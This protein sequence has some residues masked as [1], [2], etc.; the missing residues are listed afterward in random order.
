[1][2]VSTDDIITAP[3]QEF[4]RI[5]GIGRSKTYEL[6]DEGKLQSIKIGK[7]RLIV[8]RSWKQL[9]E[10]KLAAAAQA[11]LMQYEPAAKWPPRACQHPEAGILQKTA[12]RYRQRRSDP[13]KH[14]NEQCPS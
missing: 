10:E 6:L 2:D 12:S 5:S 4:C 3:I 9:V 14:A 8:V 11:R 13:R 7:R 1:M